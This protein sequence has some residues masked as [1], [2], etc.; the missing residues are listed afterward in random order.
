MIYLFVCPG[1]EHLLAML[2][3]KPLVV[4]CKFTWNRQ[5]KLV[6]MIDL[7]KPKVEISHQTR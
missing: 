6:Q 5:T 3:V 2:R 7:W 1:L 4:S